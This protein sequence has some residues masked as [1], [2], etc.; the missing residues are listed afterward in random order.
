MRNFTPLGN[1]KSLTNINSNLNLNLR[2]ASNLVL[3]QQWS[4]FLNHRIH[5]R[6]TS[7]AGVQP[8]ELLIGEVGERGLP[9]DSR[10]LHNT[11]TAPTII[12]PKYKHAM[13]Y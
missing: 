12:K 7:H 13:R 4:T 3:L 1:L 6:P 11:I 2:L 8:L 5:A 10:V 9:W